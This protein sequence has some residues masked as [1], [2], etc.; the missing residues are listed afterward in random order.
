MEF[1]KVLC[2]EQGF[3][4]AGFAK[5]VL[6]SQTG[7]DLQ[8]AVFR[9]EKADTPAFDAR[10]A[11]ALGENGLPEPQKL[12]TTELT[13]AMAA[14]FILLTRHMS[15][16]DPE[17]GRKPDYLRRWLKGPKE[18]IEAQVDWQLERAKQQTQATAAMLGANPETRLKLVEQEIR[19]S[20]EGKI[21]PHVAAFV[22]QLGKLKSEDD[23]TLIGLVVEAMA[24]AGR[25]PAAEIKRAAVMFIES[26][27]KR[28]ESGGY[29]Q[30]DASIYALAK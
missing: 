14:S 12:D 9:S 13:L 7:F 10:Y 17:T 19:K 22:D 4:A 2:G 21:E 29:V 15:K 16:P 5:T 24:N 25:D 1:T 30:I 11:E 18:V 6:L 23:D 26:Q 27:K 28:F 3:A 8:R 20:V